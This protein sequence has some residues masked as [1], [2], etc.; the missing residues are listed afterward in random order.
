VI[1]SPWRSDFVVSPD[2]SVTAARPAGSLRIASRAADCEEVKVD[3]EIAEG[4]TTVTTIR[5]PQK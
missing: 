5:A 2:G 1:P 3:V 4:K